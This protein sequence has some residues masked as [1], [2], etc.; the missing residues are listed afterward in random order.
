M[1]YTK[2]SRNRFK[3]QRARQSIDGM[4]DDNFIDTYGLAERHTDELIP[5]SWNLIA[6]P[7]LIQDEIARAKIQERIDTLATEMSE[8]TNSLSLPTF[9]ASKPPH[10]SSSLKFTR[11]YGAIS[12]PRSVT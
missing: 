11:Q 12:T 7:R 8:G 6:L 10:Q 1:L 5:S 9:D 4:T 3:L 2:I